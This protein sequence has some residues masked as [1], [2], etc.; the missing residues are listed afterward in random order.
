MC[1][2]PRVFLK[3]PHATQFYPKEMPASIYINFT[4]KRRVKWHRIASLQKRLL[5]LLLRD[6]FKINIWLCLIN[7]FVVPHGL[8]ELDANTQSRV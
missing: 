1:R 8:W 6:L 7:I 3:T 2:L 5:T 4:P